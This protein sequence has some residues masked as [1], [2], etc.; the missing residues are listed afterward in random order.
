MLWWCVKLIFGCMSV[1]CLIQSCLPADHD[2]S[3][4]VNMCPQKAFLFRD[5]QKPGKVKHF[6]LKNHHLT[7]PAERAFS[8]WASFFRHLPAFNPEKSYNEDA[9][10]ALSFSLTVHKLSSRRGSYAMWKGWSITRVFSKWPYRVQRSL[11]SMDPLQFD[12]P[13]SSEFGTCR[14]SSGWNHFR[15]RN[16]EIII[17]D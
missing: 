4:M 13:L 3:L 14:S 7:F 17:S 5:F 8:Q 1:Y 16:I 9:L 12:F 10:G 15:L 6:N 11:I 2:G